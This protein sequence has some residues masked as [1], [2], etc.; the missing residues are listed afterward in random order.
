[1]TAQPGGDRR[2]A[3]PLPA[4]HDDLSTLNP[5]GRGMSGTGE[6]ADLTLFLAITRCP[7]VQQF[8]HDSITSPPSTM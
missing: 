1:M 3:H 4:Q 8:R 2:A 6:P 7:G 5:V